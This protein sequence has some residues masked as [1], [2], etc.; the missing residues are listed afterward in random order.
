LRELRRLLIA[1]SAALFSTGCA[2]TLDDDRAFN[3]RRDEGA[4]AAQAKDLKINRQAIFRLTKLE[5]GFADAGGFRIAYTFA[6]RDADRPLFL[7][8]GGRDFLRSRHA[9]YYI[10]RLASYGFGDMLLFDYPGYGDSGGAARIDDFRRAAAAM[11]GAAKSR[12]KADQRLILWGYSLGAF[13]CAEIAGDPEVDA[14]ILEAAAADA[15]VFAKT[16]QP[17]LLAPFISV[18]VAPEFA[19]FDNAA[20][21]SAYGRPILALAGGKDRLVP[22]AAAEALAEA[23]RSSGADVVF[24]VFP[25]ATHTRIWPEAT[26]HKTVK[27]FADDKL[28]GLYPP[29]RLRPRPI[30]PY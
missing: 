13:A 5:H 18:K 7:Y 27:S 1:L 22:A 26:F 28:P 17:R 15:K 19:A 12:L 9:A 2:L 3:P 11:L 21:L 6:T 10:S 4:P 29:G 23:L 16:G 14:L 25:A 20:T 24:H 30:G 8:C